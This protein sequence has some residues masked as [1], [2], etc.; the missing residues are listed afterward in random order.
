MFPLYRA[1]LQLADRWNITHSFL[2]DEA[3]ITNLDGA[4][5]VGEQQILEFE[6]AMRYTEVMH[7]G[8]GWGHLHCPNPC[9]VFA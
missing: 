1:Y 8:H 6:V 4:K 7:V 9:S 3:E 2:P 5:I